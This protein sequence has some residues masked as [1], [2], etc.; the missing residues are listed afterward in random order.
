M[1]NQ[2]SSSEHPFAQYIRILGKGKTGTRALTQEEARDAFA[3]VLRNEAD[4]LQVGA[5]LMLLRVEEETPEELAGFVEASRGVMK[6]PPE[7]LRVDLDWSSYA[8]KRHQHPW[9]LLSA[10]LLAQSGYRVLMHGSAGHTPGRLYSEQALCALG[11][12]AATSWEEAGQ[13]L[14]R[15]GFSYLGL[16]SIC[17]GLND[18]LQLRPLLGVRSPV[19][20][21]ARILNP[22][23]AA[24]SIQSV[25]H[26]AY[27]TLHQ[28]AGQLLSHKNTAAFKG[29]SGEVEIK[30]QA[31]TA[32][33]WLYNNTIANDTL[34]RTL[35]QR[36]ERVNS[37]CVKPLVAQWRG[38]SMDTYGASAIAGTT[39]VAL[40][41]IH[42]ELSS[43]A[44]L[45]RAA[46]LWNARNIDFL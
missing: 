44:A 40:R 24:A 14:D 23:A 13:Q 35:S 22:L 6:P 1:P 3:M 37:P 46:S 7:S 10:L 29:E 12:P 45:E 8:G 17:P 9:Y 34:K 39:S 33:A 20:T 32:I 15:T 18:L 42:P 2:R 19:N 5:F 43:D 11:I 21:L 28:S 41:L 16:E 36:P 4:P 27:A 31:D 38:E 25:F 26:P 30:P